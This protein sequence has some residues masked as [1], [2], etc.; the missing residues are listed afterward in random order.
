MRHDAG[1]RTAV[2]LL[3]ALLIASVACAARAE[4]AEDVRVDVA[5]VLVSDVSRSIDDSEFVLQKSGYLAALT[6]DAVLAA[7]AG[8]PHGAIA[9]AYVEFAS[10]NQ[11]RTVLDF[12]VVRDAATARA[13]ADR[14]VAAPRSFSG[15]TAIGAGIAE[16]MHDLAASP[17]Q[18]ARQV[19]DVCG[20]GTNNS[21]PDVAVV[22][23]AAVGA[24]MT[25]NGLTIINDHPASFF[26][27]HVQPPGGLTQY[28]RDHVI[29]G[30]GAFV[31][32]VH[33]FATFGT[34]MTRKLV[35][36]IAAAPTPAARGQ[37]RSASAAR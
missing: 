7:I 6:S 15:R 30:P 9:I 27:A 17:F 11:V 22:R 18:G 2:R 12:A 19:I 37:Q 13:L 32:E 20:D 24:G 8:G 3:L 16:A 25:V 26:F 31:L 34:A 29:G 5:V 4:D 23:D 36:E 10:D 14:I 28:Y 1:M 21:G 35:D 33:D